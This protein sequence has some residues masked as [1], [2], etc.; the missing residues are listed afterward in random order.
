MLSNAFFCMGV[1]FIVL[2]M[3]VLD[4]VSIR[5]MITFA[6]LKLAVFLN[7]IISVESWSLEFRFG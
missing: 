3:C 1:T 6:D 7:H 5:K 2:S 4:V